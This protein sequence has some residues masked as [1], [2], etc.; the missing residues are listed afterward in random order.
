MVPVAVGADDRCTYTPPDCPEME[1]PARTT[2]SLAGAVVWTALSVTD[3]M[4]TAVARNTGM[5]ACNLGG[6]SDELGG[7]ATEGSGVGLEELGA[8][9]QA[10]GGMIGMPGLL[11]PIASLLTRLG[12]LVQ[13]LNGNA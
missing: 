7:S 12:R 2:R 1:Y 11:A 5:L 13:D 9:V 10:L 3:I 4:G 6:W 8:L